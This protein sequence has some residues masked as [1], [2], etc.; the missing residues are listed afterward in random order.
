M[1]RRGFTLLEVM[2]AMA[3]LAMGMTIILSSQAGLF[4]TAQRVQ[5][6]THAASLMRCKMNEIELGLLE[7]GYPLIEQTDSGECCEDEDNDFTCEWAIQTVELPQPA[8][9]ADTEEFDVGEED[10]ASAAVSPFGAASGVGALPTQGDALTGVSGMSDLAG[11]LGESAEGGGM[12]SM[13]LGLVYPTL[14]PMLEASIRKV[15]VSVI[16]H[17]GEKERR[18]DAVQ[19]VTN[20]LEGNLNPNMGETL[21]ELSEQFAT[22]TSSAEV[23]E[24]K[25]EDE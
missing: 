4:A 15:K 10:E 6:E 25:G 13:A 24:E 16:W 1:S 21:E 20:P 7:D 22:G 12:V 23:A 18:L 3:I 8:T 17:E 2:V 9:F 5:S 11:E 14:K 19:Y